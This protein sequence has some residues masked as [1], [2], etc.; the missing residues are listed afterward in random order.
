MEDA[1]REVRLEAVSKVF[2][3]HP[4][5][6]AALSSVSLS[7]RRGEFVS[8]VGPSGCG[9][10]TL[11]RIVADLTPPTSGSVEVCGVSPSRARRDRQL[12]MVF[13]TPVLYPWRTVIGNVE[14][15]LEVAG[16]TRVERRGR[17][18]E[19]LDLVGLTEFKDRRPRQLSGG[20]QQRVGLARA[21][22]TEAPIL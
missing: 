11:L 15:P 16:L 5:G 1:S 2:S 4:G 3:D 9:K 6:T 12:G 10:S 21:F 18:L 19:T 20:M 14:L 17:A 22:A 8:I 13:Q 7:I